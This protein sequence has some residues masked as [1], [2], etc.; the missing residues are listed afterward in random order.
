MDAAPREIESISADVLFIARSV[1]L[2]STSILI[3]STYPQILA[4]H[5][6]RSTPLHPFPRTNTSPS[7]L[8]TPASLLSPPPGPLLCVI[9]SDLHSK[10]RPAHFRPQFGDSSRPGPSYTMATLQHRAF[11]SSIASLY[12]HQQNSSKKNMPSP[13]SPT[14]SSFSVPSPFSSASS[15]SFPNENSPISESHFDHIPSPIAANSNAAGF[16]AGPVSVQMF[17]P[18]GDIASPYASDFDYGMMDLKKPQVPSLRSLPPSHPLSSLRQGLAFHKAMETVY[19]HPPLPPQ[20]HSQT[21]TPPT[22]RPLAD[23]THSSPP[24]TALAAD[25]VPS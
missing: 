22:V 8:D 4:R 12:F 19:I 24:T 5:R 20:R 25:T 2:R 11:P 1:I 3:Q 23:I 9:L 21:T 16:P 10:V 18:Q 13:L 6:D 15:N 14:Y 17:A 7:R